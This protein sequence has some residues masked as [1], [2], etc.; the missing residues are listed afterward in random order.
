LTTLAELESQLESAQTAK[1]GA[2]ESLHDL[3]TS[4]KQVQER[5]RELE[6]TCEQLKNER[7]KCRQQIA[8]LQTDSGTSNFEVEKVHNFWSEIGSARD[9]VWNLHV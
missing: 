3:E 2:L 4:S 9:V 1:D 6:E 8:Q 5:C 7:D